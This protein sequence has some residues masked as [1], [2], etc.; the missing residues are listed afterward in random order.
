MKLAEEAIYHIHYTFLAR[1]LTAEIR[2]R[3]CLLLVPYK[4]GEFEE[5]FGSLV[6]DE[7]SSGD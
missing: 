1:M 4:E 3:Y 6:L 5:K 2:P 7:D